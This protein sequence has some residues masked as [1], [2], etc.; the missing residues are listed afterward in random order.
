MTRRRALWLVAA[1]VLVGVIAFVFWP[2]SERAFYD[3]IEERKAAGLPTTR[4]EVRGPAPS[5]EENGAE[6]LRAAWAALEKDQGPT[7]SWK[8]SG[9][10][11]SIDLGDRT[12]PDGLSTEQRTDLAK[13]AERLRPGIDQLV[14]AL[15]RPRLVF[16]VTFGANGWRDVEPQMMLVSDATRALQIQAAGN[17]DPAR[18]LAACRASLLLADR[19]EPS[20]W[21]EWVLAQWARTSGVSSLRDGVETGRLDARDARAACDGLLATSVLARYRAASRAEAVELLENYRALVEGRAVPSTAKLTPWKRIE[22]RVDMARRRFAGTA[23]P[24][25][26]DFEPGIAHVIVAL[27]R[28]R[29]AIGGVADL[30]TL[31]TEDGLAAIDGTGLLRESGPKNGT[32]KLTQTA[33]RNEAAVRLARVALAAAGFRAT[34]GD[35]PVS[36][37]DLRPMFPDGVPLD[38]FAEAPFVYE[39][40]ATGVRIAS[41]GRL[42]DADPVDQQRLRDQGLA[43]EL[44]R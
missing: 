7:S 8:G 11:E 40:T 21:L 14:R 13:T 9:F 44:K 31:A 20:S 38:P 6:D 5:A 18:R 35:F 29:D 28:S 1:A 3:Y 12:W 22:H 32:V 23:C 10:D 2:W 15:D 43:W 30:R 37:D 25:D 17:A 41:T 16:P 42:A 36:I 24:L 27:C 34:H 39:R 4:D 19:A 33:L 26:M